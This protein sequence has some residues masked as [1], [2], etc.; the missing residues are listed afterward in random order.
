MVMIAMH[1]GATDRG[2]LKHFSDCREPFVLVLANLEVFGK[3]LERKA[4]LEACAAPMH[5]F[6]LSCKHNKGFSKE[7]KE[8]GWVEEWKGL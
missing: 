7:D 3:A 2:E 8:G 5:C 6:P 1:S 4:Q